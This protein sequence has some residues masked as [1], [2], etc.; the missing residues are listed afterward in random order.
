M[1]T[2]KIE[3]Y[4]MCVQ[5]EKLAKQNQEKAMEENR[6]TADLRKDNGYHQISN[7]RLSVQRKCRQPEWSMSLQMEL[8]ETLVQFGDEKENHA[9]KLLA[10]K[11]LR[12][13]FDTQ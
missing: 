12:Q 2:L 7:R 11:H 5:L 10:P 1:K 3:I 9:Q 6:L 4:K 8:D 13:D